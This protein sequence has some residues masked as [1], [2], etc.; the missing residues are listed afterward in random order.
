MLPGNGGAA[1][2]SG[3]MHLD[4]VYNARVGSQLAWGDGPEILAIPGEAAG[5]WEKSPWWH[6]PA[7]TAGTSDPSSSRAVGRGGSS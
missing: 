5:E 2:G 3:G 1:R 4:P 7:I 6:L